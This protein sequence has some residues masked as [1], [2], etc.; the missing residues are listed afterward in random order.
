MKITRK[1]SSILIVICMILALFPVS[2]FAEGEATEYS[3]FTIVGWE[4]EGPEGAIKSVKING[5]MLPETGGTITAR[6]ATTLDV[7]IVL[8][9]GYRIGTGFDGVIL[10]MGGVQSGY[11]NITN[12]NN[13]FSIETPSEEWLNGT[14][15]EDAEDHEIYL[16]IPTEEGKMINEVSLTITPPLCGTV[17]TFDESTYLQSPLPV[18]TIPEDA[19]YILD[20]N[21]GWVRSDLSGYYY[22]TDEDPYMVGGKSYAAY[23]WLAPKEGY[24]FSTDVKVS[25][26]GGVF[27]QSNEKAGDLMD[28]LVNVQPEHVPGDPVTENE[29]LPTCLDDGS[30]DE[31]VYCQG[32]GAELSRNTVTD[33]AI[34]HD[35]GKWTITRE[36]AIGAAG[37]EQRICKRDASH[38]ETR[39][40]DPLVGY[41]VTFDANGHGTAPDAQTVESGKTAEKPKNPTAD[42]YAFGGW[43][44]DAKCTT[45]FDFGTAITE[46]ITLYAKWTKSSEK[47]GD[48]VP[49]TGDSSSMTL[50]IVLAGISLLGMAATI[51]ER[52][53]LCRRGR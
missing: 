40:I 22:S 30:H 39:A 32:C 25:V 2:A 3:E 17:V 8:N 53:R 20:D 49:K 50:W 14:Y 6:P 11:T 46:D 27:L 24:A 7:E 31:V 43:Y 19:P 23:F 35:W 9:E 36:P 42:G 44:T 28:V 10:R 48:A 47:S 15:G 26:N 16:I 5:A 52:K 29:V 12:S 41:T 34:G 51:Y 45:V 38:V 4:N 13:A 37:E 21:V 33:K 1:L 18:V